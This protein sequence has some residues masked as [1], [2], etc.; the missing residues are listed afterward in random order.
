MII[1]MALMIGKKV[2]M[3]YICVLL[4]V[5]VLTF[6]VS[7]Y[8]F[9]QDERLRMD[10]ERS[11]RRSLFMKDN[12]YKKDRE[13]ISIQKDMDSNAA[14]FHLLYCTEIIMIFVP[15]IMEIM[16]IDIVENKIWIIFFVAFA[17]FFL[18]ILREYYVVKQVEELDKNFDKNLNE[19]KIRK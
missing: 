16:N 18:L 2:A 8:F 4:A 11:I 14:L 17:L 15:I 1:I 6:I 10:R 19:V 12:Y 7:P 9:K 3:V 13:I 5:I